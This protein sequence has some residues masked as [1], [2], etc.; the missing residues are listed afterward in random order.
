MGWYADAK[1]WIS[2]GKC[3]N[4][5]DKDM[6]VCIGEPGQ[7][8]EMRTLKPGEST[9]PDED[10]D[11]IM[12]DDGGTTKIWGRFNWKTEHDSNWARDNWP[13]CVN[14]IAT[15]NAQIGG[16]T[17]RFTPPGITYGVLSSDNYGWTPN[18]PNGWFAGSRGQSIPIDGVFVKSMSSVIDI[19]FYAHSVANLNDSWMKG[20]GAITFG[21][22]TNKVFIDGF[23]IRLTRGSDKYDVIYKVHVQ[24]HGDSVFFSNGVVVGVR[25]KRIEGIIIGVVPKGTSGRLIVDP[26]VRIHNNY[27][28]ESVEEIILPS[29]EELIYSD[30]RLGSVKKTLEEMKDPLLENYMGFPIFHKDLLLDE[31]YNKFPIFIPDLSIS[32]NIPSKSYQVEIYDQE[33]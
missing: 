30:Y 25:G 3:T 7:P 33:I 15:T 26:F 32:G 19:E 2:E 8:H 9:R 21:G 6:Q 17:T 1:D 24:D 13:Q 16:T 11:G 5:T 12:R 14:H 18:M 22:P 29:S 20:S 27:R 10:C 31:G 28:T 4:K 23:A